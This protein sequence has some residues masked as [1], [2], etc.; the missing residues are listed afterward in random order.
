MPFCFRV[1]YRSV[2]VLFPNCNLLY[3]TFPHLSNTLAEFC[4]LRTKLI[5]QLREICMLLRRENRR[6]LSNSIFAHYAHFPEQM[7]VAPVLPLFRSAAPRG[8]FR[9]L[10]LPPQTTRATPSGAALLD[11]RETTV[12]PTICVCGGVRSPRPTRKTR[13]SES[14]HAETFSLLEYKKRDACSRFL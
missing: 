4:V 6:P 5:P 1:C 12:S 14:S 9:A 3:F 11:Y 10:S 7:A 8:V 13:T 2:S